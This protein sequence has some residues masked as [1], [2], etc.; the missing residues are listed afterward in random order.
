MCFKYAERTLRGI[1]YQKKNMP[2]AFDKKHKMRE[3]LIGWVYC[4]DD[5]YLW[6]YDEVISALSRVEIESMQTQCMVSPMQLLNDGC[7]EIGKLI[8]WKNKI[9]ILPREISKKWIFYDIGSGKVDYGAVCTDSHRLADAIL[10]ENVLVIFSVFVKDPILVVDLMERKV[11]KRIDFGLLPQKGMHIMDV[12]VDQG[13]IRFLIR[14]SSFCGR[15]NSKGIHLTQIRVKAPFAC[16]DFFDG[17]GW[18]V[19]CKGD[20]LY[21]FDSDG[22]IL[23]CYKINLGIEFKRIVFEG[24]R[25]FLLSAYEGM[26]KIFDIENGYEINVC[27]Q[28]ES[29][30]ANLPEL[31]KQVDYWGYMKKDSD[32]W[33]LP[34]KY[35]LQIVNIDTLMCRQEMLQYSEEF[36]ENEYWEYCRYARKM[37]RFIYSE[38]LPN[39]SLER[40]VELIKGNKTSIDRKSKSSSGKKIW[41]KFK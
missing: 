19:T 26:I 7:F 27:A 6:C 28:Q 15:L 21:H 35:P 18:A 11:V 40:Y 17:T 1:L 22:T 31:F 39:E 16:A 36:S 13:D 33:F 9:I 30:F 3:K 20:L 5:K 41:D 4:Q 37:K 14:N 29:N 38:K 25:I 8:K 12:T 23:D 24:G 34:L 2:L 10:F 32:I